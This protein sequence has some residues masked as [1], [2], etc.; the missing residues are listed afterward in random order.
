MVCTVSSLFFTK[1]DEG[2][3]PLRQTTA[4]EDERGVETADGTMA[5]ASLHQKGRELCN[6]TIEDLAHKRKI[7]GLS[8]K[9]AN[10]HGIVAAC[11]L[12]IEMAD[13]SGKPPT[14]V[15]I[16]QTM[17]KLLANANGLEEGAV[18]R[19]AQEEFYRKGQKPERNGL[20]PLLGP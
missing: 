20:L 2:S 15:L 11:G 18:I 5:A 13:T 14:C 19:Y 8:A 10:Q 9:A 7:T 3:V 16:L 17:I 6:M 1:L 4:L 12:Q